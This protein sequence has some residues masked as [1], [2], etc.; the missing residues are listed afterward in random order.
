M[1]VFTDKKYN[2]LQSWAIPRTMQYKQTNETLSK[3]KVK[4]TTTSFIGATMNYPKKNRFQSVPVAALCLYNIQREDLVF[5]TFLCTQ[6]KTPM[7]SIFKCR[8]GRNRANATKTIPEPGN[9]IQMGYKSILQI[10]DT[11]IIG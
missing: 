4:Q 8:K 7:L 5:K 2:L 10:A 9:R 11:H 3:I 1:D 6:K